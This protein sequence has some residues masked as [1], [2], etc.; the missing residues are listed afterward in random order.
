METVFCLFAYFLVLL[1]SG[2]R[3]HDMTHP[4]RVSPRLA[5]M[6]ATAYYV[7]L[8]LSQVRLTA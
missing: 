8:I 5:A 1:N 4:D 6:A 7:T 3:F 2:L